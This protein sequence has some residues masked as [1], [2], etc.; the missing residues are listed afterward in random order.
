M[1]MPRKEKT[2][3]G[4]LAAGAAVLAMW[5]AEPPS[6]H[7]DVNPDD[8]E[9]FCS[10]LD[11]DASPA[12]FFREAG[13]M[14]LDGLTKDQAAELIVYAIG[15]VCPEYNDE[16]QVAVDSLEKKPVLNRAV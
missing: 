7:A 12:T 8:A 4:A 1:T 13:N 2:I 10:R 15:Q 9:L 3:L 16:F 14:I 5:I 6:A 11:V